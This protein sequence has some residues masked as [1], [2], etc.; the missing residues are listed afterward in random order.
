[1]KND[2][3]GFDARA[4]YWKHSL[5][6]LGFLLVM[7][8]VGHMFGLDLQHAFAFA[9]IGDTA[10]ISP[11]TST[12]TLQKAWRK[13]QGPL[14]KGF[15]SRNKEWKLLKDVP[16]YDEIDYSAREM[17]IPV[18]LNRQGGAAHIPE[19]GYEGNPTTRPPEEITVNWTLLSQRFSATLTA[20]R[21]DRT[22]KGRKGQVTRQFKY[23]AIKAMDSVSARVSHAF[24]GYNTA[25]ICKTS[26]VGTGATQTLTLIDGYGETGSAFDNPA[27]LAQFFAVG[28]K[29]ALV[30]AGALVANAVGDITNVSETAGTVD[31]T[32]SGSVTSANGD[33]I[34]FANNALAGL[35][36]TLTANTDY[37][38]WTPGLLDA[39]KSTSLHGLTHAAWVAGYASSS[40]GR[41]SRLTV[42]K[43]KQGIANKGGGVMNT[44]LLDEQVENDFVQGQEA[45][46]RFGDTKSF[47]LGLGMDEK[48]Y[49][50]FSSDRMLPGFAV[51][52]DRNNS[53]HR[54]LGIDMPE[55]EDGDLGWEDGHKMEN[56]NSL[57][58]N[59]D[60]E[61]GWVTTN[62][63]NLAYAEGLTR[64]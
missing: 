18:D 50:V 59:I 47:S 44:L 7:L 15:R 24:Y 61:Y 11:T 48:E 13:V 30:R 60:F 42:R 49:K 27:F 36:W 33:S 14:V 2:L 20:K 56:Q 22:Q 39:L 58:F 28:D 64:Q 53:F 6:R 52:M 9:V 29:I 23:S 43:M 41:F 25:V 10:T 55:G 40:G 63:G 4:F 34:V 1:M 12:G 35:T 57:L 45:A 17:L 37:L 31:V 19:G 54:F 38:K 3:N 32:W 16:Q 26:T 46:A 8:L 5:Q 62:R 21:L 51:G